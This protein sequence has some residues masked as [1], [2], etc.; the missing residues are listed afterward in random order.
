MYRVPDNTD[1]SFLV[2]RELL[3]V[4]IGLHQVSLRFDGD[5]AINIECEFNHSPANTTS[6]RSPGLPTKAASLVSLIGTKIASAASKDT[7]T[8][9]IAFRNNETLEIYDSNTSYESFQVFAAG[10]EI[11]V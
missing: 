3:Q 11:I 1:W 2:D 10:R 4:C 8:L 7:K 6:S 5:V 9:A